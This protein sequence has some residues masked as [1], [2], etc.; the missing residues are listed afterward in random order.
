MGNLMRMALLSGVTVAALT[1]PSTAAN[2]A[3]NSF[4]NP[5]A[6]TIN[7]GNTATPYPSIVEVAGQCG[8]IT[9][10][11]VTFAN[12]SHTFPDDIDALLVSPTGKKTLLMSDAGGTNDLTGLT[13]TFDDAAA[14][15]L[16]DS[17][18]I[19]S[20]TYKPTD[21]N[22]GSDTFSV[23]APG[24]PYVASLAEFNGTAPNGKWQLFVTD[25]SPGDPA[26]SIA[27]GWMLTLT[28]ADCPLPDADGDGVPDNSDACPS[29][30]GPASNNGCPLPPATDTDPPETKISKPPPASS[31]LSKVKVKF[32][33]DEAFSTFECKLDK[34]P[35]KPC[36]SPKSYKVKPGRHKIRVRASDKAGNVDATPAKAKFKIRDV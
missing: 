25:D 9:D 16:P 11:N 21:F 28:T 26:G 27:G 15:P 14:A 32:K 29:V 8:T 3:T 10:A 34:K 35:Y 36:T 4:S 31:A 18:A 20:G 5:Q 22:P 7:D 19:T 30:A 12:V 2:A 13:L 17:T 33:S 23:P 24:G 6:I 1:L